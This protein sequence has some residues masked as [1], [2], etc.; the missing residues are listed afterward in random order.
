MAEVACGEDK[1]G[2]SEEGDSDLWRFERHG[3]MG[4]RIRAESARDRGDGSVS[5]RGEG[6]R[7]AANSARARAIQEYAANREGG[8]RGD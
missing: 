7:V 2:G 3:G 4:G 6:E 5:A 8:D 1:G